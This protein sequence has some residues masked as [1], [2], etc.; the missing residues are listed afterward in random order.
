MVLVPLF[1]QPGILV[2]VGLKSLDVP[3]AKLEEVILACSA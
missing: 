1:A 2:L 3:I